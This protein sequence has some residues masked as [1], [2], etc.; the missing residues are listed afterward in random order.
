MGVK[1][2]NL[3]EQIISVHSDYIWRF[4]DTRAKCVSF[5][6]LSFGVPWVPLGWGVCRENDDSKP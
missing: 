2:S 4:G 1:I 6:R 3:F 5:H